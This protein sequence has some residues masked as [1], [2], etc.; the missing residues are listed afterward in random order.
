MSIGAY[1]GEPD[2]KRAGRRVFI[3]AFVIANV[4]S[5]PQ[6]A[7]EFADGYLWVGVEDLIVSVVSIVLLVAIHFWPHRIVPLLTGMFVAITA[8]YLIS[9]T[10]YGGLYSSGLI[11]IYGMIVMLAALTTIG[12]RAGIVWFA[13]YVAAVVYSV[14]VEGRIEPRYVI[15]DPLPGAMTALLGSGLVSIA[16]L[17]YFIRQR[18]RFQQRSDALLHAILPDEVAARLKDGE[19]TIAN[20]LPEASVL[21]AD[22]VGFTPM[23]ATMSPAQLVTLLN[24]V[25][26]AF[27]GFVAALGLEKI[28]TVGDAYMAA[29]GVPHPRPDHAN[30]IAELALQIRNHRATDPVSGEPLRFRIG[31]DSGPVTA[32]VI[33]TDKFAYDLWGDTVNTASRMESSAL[34]GTIQITDRTH[35]LLREVFVCEPRGSVEVKGKGTMETFLLVERKAA[36]PIDARPSAPTA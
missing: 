27:D 28:K 17:G 12:L 11:A 6:L 2:T 33:G 26:T 10:L 22:V 16:V 24:E 36:G 14:A 25:F 15:A 9:T 31:I 23:S 32:G 35:E 4:F 30:L 21:F 20:D 19:G 8:N 18:D 1:E 34:P 3:V 29:A 7:S 5:V 13:V